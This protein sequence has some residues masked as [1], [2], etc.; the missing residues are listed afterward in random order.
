LPPSSPD[1][2]YGQPKAIMGLSLQNFDQLLPLAHSE[3]ERIALIWL[4]QWTVT[5][6]VAL[7]QLFEER[8]RGGFVREC[9]GDLH[10]GNI[11]L[12][13]GRI[14]VFDCIEF[15]PELRW[16]DVM[17]GVA[18][19]TM[20]LIQHQRTDLAYR[21]LD[22][23]LQITGD[24]RGVYLLRY[25]M[26]YRAMVRAK[27]A[28]MRAVQAGVNIESQR[29]LHK[30]CSDHVTLAKQLATSAHPM[31]VILHG[32]SAQVRPLFHKSCYRR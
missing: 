12:I 13:D 28:G 30:K 20:D 31:L 15:N 10:L 7:E 21:L 26:I 3:E 16:I 2:L 23:Y 32:L 17:N 9:H 6:H 24:Y 1:R 19:L 11:A 8:Q 27:V 29:L 22:R 5:Q 14:R 18:V 4:R 25:Y